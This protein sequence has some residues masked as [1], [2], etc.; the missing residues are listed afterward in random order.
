MFHLHCCSPI[1]FF[2]AMTPLEVQAAQTLSVAVIVFAFLWVVLVCVGRGRAGKTLSNGGWRGQQQQQRYGMSSP[3]TGHGTALIVVGSVATLDGGRSRRQR[4]R[5]TTRSPPWQPPQ[6]R[7]RQIES[8]VGV[9]DVNVVRD[10]DVPDCGSCSGTSEQ[11]WRLPGGCGYPLPI[12][13]LRV[14][15]G[16][17]FAG[18][19]RRVVSLRSTALW[20]CTIFPIL[21]L[22]KVR[23]FYTIQ[24]DP[25]L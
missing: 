19:I 21:T 14:V 15:T 17:C 8:H 6:E 12:C 2:R 9:A 10:D 5:R 23:D 16:Q 20:L 1:A 22:A 4:R 7:S 25:R 13:F 3:R 11:T 18:V 24:S